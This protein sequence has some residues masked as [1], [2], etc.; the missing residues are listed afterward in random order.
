MASCFC[1]VNPSGF[2]FG[3]SQKG[4]ICSC[5]GDEQLFMMQHMEN[6]MIGGILDDNVWYVDSRASN[7]MTSHGEWFRDT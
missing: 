1:F 2:L 5:E 4:T 3:L 7:H 6:S